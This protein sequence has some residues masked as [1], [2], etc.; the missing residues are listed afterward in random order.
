[1]CEECRQMAILSG[2]LWRK[3]TYDAAIVEQMI[4]DI[5]CGDSAQR[6]IDKFNIK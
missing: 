2:A 3:P 4:N 5:L 6:V 1:M